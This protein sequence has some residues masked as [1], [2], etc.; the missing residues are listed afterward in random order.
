MSIAWDKRNKRWRFYFDRTIASQ[1]A[2]TSKLLPAGWSHAQARAYDKAEE[3]RLYALASGIERVDDRPPIS[4]AVQLYLDHRI[5][6]LRNGKKAAQDLAHLV[7]WIEARALP[8]LPAVAREYRAD[9][10][11]LAPATLRNRLAYLKAAVRYAYRRHGFGDRDYS[12]RM[13]LPAAHNERHEYITVAEFRRL[14]ARVLDPEARDLFTLAFYT[15]L[16]WRANLLTLTR[17]Q[18]VRS[19]SRVWLS[20]RRTKNDAPLMI[21]VHRDARAALRSIPFT[22]GDSA[23]YRAFRSAVRAIRRPKLRP[24]DLRHSLASVLA[25]TGASL[26]EIGAVLGH[27]SVQASRRYAHI[28][29][30]RVA[31]LISSV[32]LSRTRVS[33]GTRKKAA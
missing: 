22:R 15:G 29:P 3:A 19:G 33:R 30:E 17:E 26:Q 20:I 8:D 32:G 5:P 6:E 12:E 2:R 21:P 28:Y 16:R 24:H 27:K 14:M 13:E 25:S 23:Y 10:A 31:E 18:I 7:P 11:D 4:R 9:N 1:R